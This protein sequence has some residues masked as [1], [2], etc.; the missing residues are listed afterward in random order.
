MSLIIQ[1]YPSRSTYPVWDV[2]EG[3]V[4]HPPVYIT[5]KWDGTTMQA[6]EISQLWWMKSGSKIGCMNICALWLYIPSYIHIWN[7]ICVCIYI[8]YVKHPANIQIQ[9]PIT[10]C[11]TFQPI[12]LSHVFT[13][14]HHHPHWAP[15]RC[16]KFEATAKHIFKRIDQW[17]CATHFGRFWS[18]RNSWKIGSWK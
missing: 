6:M 15:W 8:W 2:H 3:D 10:C 17:G 1:V 7:L 11:N 4:P 12:S 18:F 16:D 5:E 9:L 14:S 13:Q